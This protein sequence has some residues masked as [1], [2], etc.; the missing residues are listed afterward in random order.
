VL[1]ELAAVAVLDVGQHDAPVGAA[2]QRDLRDAREVLPDLVAVLR[3][4]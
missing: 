4:G 1:G 2:V 3:F